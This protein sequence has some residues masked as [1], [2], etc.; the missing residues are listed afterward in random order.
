VTSRSETTERLQKK[1]PKKLKTQNETRERE[2]KKTQKLHKTYSLCDD[3]S[4]ESVAES[5]NFFERNCQIK[6]LFM[7]FY[8]LEREALSKRFL[9]LESKAAPATSQ[10]AK[11]CPIKN[12]KKKNNTTHNGHEKVLIVCAPSINITRQSIYHFQFQFHR[13]AGSFFFLQP[14]YLFIYDNPLFAIA[15]M[16]CHLI[17]KKSSIFIATSSRLFFDSEI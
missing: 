9:L 8:I 6:L 1:I 17:N 16:Q 7:F 10:C 14:K 15:M 3:R 11:S 5:Q 12:T 2:K 4:L 13:R